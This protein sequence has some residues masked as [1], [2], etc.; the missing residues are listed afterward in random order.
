MGH[1]YRW[2]PKKFRKA[3]Y[4]VKIVDGEPLTDK[5]EKGAFLDVNGATYYTL[6]QL[7]KIARTFRQGEVKNEDIFFFGD[8]EFP[9]YVETIKRLAELQNINVKLYGFL[10]AGSYTRED[11]VS[12]LAPWHKYFELGWLKV[13][14]GVFVGTYYHKSQVVNLR[15]KPYAPEEDQQELINKI[16]V[17]GNP[18]NTEEV[19]SMVQPLPKKEN[20]IIFPNRFDYEKRPNLFLDL[21]LILAD[22]YPDLEYVVTTSH[23]SIKSNQPWL[24]KLCLAI[25][26]RFKGK[27]MVY[28]NLEKASYYY[29]LAKSKIMFSSSI[30]ENFGYTVLEAMTFGTNP[31]LPNNYSYPELVNGDRRFLY[32]NLDEALEKVPKLLKTYSHNLLKKARVYD[33]SI[34]RMI[35][36]MEENND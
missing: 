7:Q 20:I 34:D 8:I 27:L 35:Q 23:P 33:R 30:E 3:G 10:H 25:Q 13:C 28:K 15:V 2:F 36:I 9:G 5:I 17:T 26:E 29:L 11:F 18:W 6:T 14:D 32:S 16:H 1:W 19:R 22:E 31:L 21:C 4:N 12:K 24:V